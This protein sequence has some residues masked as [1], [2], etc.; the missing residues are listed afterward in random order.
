VS[1]KDHDEN[2]K[3]DGCIY[4]K[5]VSGIFQPITGTEFEFADWDG[6]QALVVT[7]TVREAQF[8]V[9]FSK[10]FVGGGNTISIDMPSSFGSVEQFHVFASLTGRA[11]ATAQIERLFVERLQ[12]LEADMNRNG[13]VN[14]NDLMM[15][16]WEWLNQE[17]LEGCEGYWNFDQVNG[18]YIADSSSAMRRGVLH[19]TPSWQSEGGKFDGA[20]MFDGNDDYAEILGYTGISG[21]KSRTVCAWVKTSSGG[22]IIGWGDDQSDVG[23]WLLT[24]DQNGK[25]AVDTGSGNVTGD[26]FIADGQWHHVTAVLNNDDCTTTED[27]VLYVDGNSIS[28]TVVSGVVATGGDSITAYNSNVKIGFFNVYFNG[29]IDDVAVFSDSLAAGQLHDIYT[30]GLHVQSPANIRGGNVVNFYD[31][32]TLASSWL[33]TT[34]SCFE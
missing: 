1:L 7:M 22:D 2:G 15:F 6:S 23:K 3:I 24:I 16:L 13:N 4:E 26:V 20:L 33:D 9:D 18:G 30:D 5:D 10:D 11:G 19:G 25:F 31:F 14:L 34:N 8:D 29:L 12:P 17:G 21:T 27:I 28:S 32:A